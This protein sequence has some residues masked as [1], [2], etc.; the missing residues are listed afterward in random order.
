MDFYGELLNIVEKDRVLREEPLRLHTTLKIG[1]PAD[2]FVKPESEEEVSAVIQLCRQNDIPY[3][4]LGNG[5]NLLVSDTGYRG[6]V[7]R[8]W[9]HI[10]I[11]YDN[12]FITFWKGLFLFPR[13][14]HLLTA[15]MYRC[16][17]QYHRTY[18]VYIIYKLKTISLK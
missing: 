4:I 2:F 5:S 7:I 12:P 10:H 3:F 8:L 14:F 13:I 11:P 17:F 1:G 16:I 6:V 15:M 18:S 9:Y